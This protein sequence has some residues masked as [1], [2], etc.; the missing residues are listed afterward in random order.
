ME[1]HDISLQGALYLIMELHEVLSPPALRMIKLK[2]KA[3]RR[4]N[5]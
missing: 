1:L 3:Q 4:I 2:L 5:F